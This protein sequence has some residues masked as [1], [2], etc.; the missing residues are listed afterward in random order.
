MEYIL[1]RVVMAK[2]PVFYVLT[3]FILLS[4]TLVAPSAH[5]A[6]SMGDCLDGNK[7]FHLKCSGTAGSSSRYCYLSQTETTN[8]EDGV[9]YA[10]WFNVWDV[11]ENSDNKSS[12]I[13]LEDDLDFGGYDDSKGACAVTFT[14]IGSG[15]S[16]DG[17]GK[18]IKGFCYSAANAGFFETLSGKEFKN[19]TFENPYVIGQYAGVVASTIQDASKVSHV[20]I[21]NASLFGVQLGGLAAVVKYVNNS[22]ENAINNV[23]IDGLSL[24][25]DRTYL[26]QAATFYMGSAV[27]YVNNAKVSV[28]NANVDNISV[29]FPGSATLYLGGFFGETYNSTVNVSNSIITSNAGLEPEG[30]GNLYVGGVVG[31]NYASHLTV[32]KFGFNGNLSGSYAGGILGYLKDFTSPAKNSII[33]NTYTVGEIK[34]TTSA[35]YI[36]GFLEAVSSLDQKDSLYHNFHFGTDAVSEGVG[37]YAG[38]G[39]WGYSWPQGTLG[40]EYVADQGNIFGNVRNASSGLTPNESFGFHFNVLHDTQN[41]VLKSYMDFFEGTYN[42]SSSAMWPMVRVANGIVKAADMESGLF[43][44]LM[45]YNLERMGQ[46]AIWIS[47]GGLPTFAN[48]TDKPNHLVILETSNLYLNQTQEN[49]LTIKNQ[50]I[51]DSSVSNNSGMNPPDRPESVK[52]GIVSYTDAS[53][54]LNS[55]FLGNVTKLIDDGK[56]NLGVNV[57]LEDGS[58]NSVSLT[59]T[60]DTYQMLRFSIPNMFFCFKENGTELVFHQVASTTPD[61]ETCFDTWYHDD[62]SGNDAYSY[63]QAWLD[64]TDNG[65]VVLTS[66]VVFAGS[67]NTV[68]ADGPNAFKGKYLE[69]GSGDSFKS[70]DGNR[71]KIIGLCYVSSTARESVGFVKTNAATSRIENIAFSNIYFKLTGNN[72]NAGVALFNVSPSSIDGISVESSEFRADSVGAIAGVANE[73]ENISNITLSGVKLDGK[74]VGSVFGYVSASNNVSFSKI[75][76]EG[77]SDGFINSTNYAGGLVGRM[78]ALSPLTLSIKNTYTRGN[79]TCSNSTVGFLVS[80]L[81]NSGRFAFDI[82]NNYH[83]GTDDVSVSEG[84]HGIGWSSGFVRNFRNSISGTILYAEGDLEYAEKPIA[85]ATRG[86]GGAVHYYNGIISAAQMKSARFAAVLNIGGAANWTIDAGNSPKNDGLPFL[87]DDTDDTYKPIYAIGFDLAYFDEWADAKAKQNLEDALYYEEYQYESIDANGTQGIV[88]YTN[89]RRKLSTEDVNFVNSLLTDVATDSWEGSKVLSD[90]QTYTENMTYTYTSTRKVRYFCFREY[91]DNLFLSHYEYT[92]PPSSGTCYAYWYDEYADHSSDD[93]PDAYSFAQ[94]WLDER[95]NGGNIYIASDITFAGRSGDYCI[96]APNAFKGKYLTLDDGRG[97]YSQPSERHVIYT[98]SGLCYNSSSARNIGFVEIKHS[99]A[100]I[101]DIAFSDVFFKLTGST[102]NTSAGLVMLQAQLDLLSDIRVFRSVFQASYAGSILGTDNDMGVGRLENITVDSDTITSSNYAGAVAGIIHGVTAVKGVYASDCK[103]SILRSNGIVIT[104]G[105]FGGIAGY[106]ANTSVASLSVSNVSVN[107]VAMNAVNSSQ[108]GGVFGHLDAGAASSFQGITVSGDILGSLVGGLVGEIW[109]RTDVAVSIKKTRILAHLW[110]AYDSDTDVLGGLIGKFDTRVAS[111]VG[112]LNINHNFITGA[113][114]SQKSQS[115]GY[116]LGSTM[117]NVTYNVTDNYYY[118]NNNISPQVGIVGIADWNNPSLSSSIITRNFR[119]AVDGS[120]EKDGD[121]QYAT[122]PIKNGDGTFDNGVIPGE[123]MKSARFAAVLNTDEAIWTIDEGDS[124]FNDGLPYFSE[125]SYRPIYVVRFDLNNFNEL[126]ADESHRNILNE[127]ISHNYYSL[128]NVDGTHKG[129]MLFTSNSGKLNDNDYNFVNSLLD[130]EASWVGSPT[131]NSEY[132]TEYR[133]NTIYTYN[134]STLMNIVNHFC[135]ANDGNDGCDMNTD[136]DLSGT[137]GLEVEGYSIGYLLPPLKTYRLGQA[138]SLIPPLMVSDGNSVKSYLPASYMINSLSPRQYAKAG[139]LWGMVSDYSTLS[140]VIQS[141]DYSVYENTIHLYY[142]NGVGA[143]TNIKVA[144]DGTTDYVVNGLAFD[145]DGALNKQVY[146]KSIPAGSY[147]TLPVTPVIMLEKAPYGFNLDWSLEFSYKTATN[148]NLVDN[149]YLVENSNVFASKY[150]TDSWK[151]ENR[152]ENDKVHL[153][154]IYTGL[155]KAFALSQTNLSQADFMITITPTLTPSNYSVTFDWGDKFHKDTLLVFSDR[156]YSQWDDAKLENV[157]MLAG[158]KFSRVYIYTKENATFQSISWTHDNQSSGYSELSSALL[159]NATGGDVSITD[160]SLY[161][162]RGSSIAS[163]GLINVF[164]YDGDGNLLTSADDYHGNV[165]LSQKIG[166]VEFKQESHFESDVMFR[167]ENYKNSDGLNVPNSPKLFL[168]G[169]G[170]DTLTFDV[171]AKAD[172]GY[173]MNV[174]SFTHG[175][176]NAPANEGWGYDADTKKLKIHTEKMQGA[177]PP[178]VPAFDYPQFT[179]E[180]I[181]LHYYL[182]FTIPDDMRDGDVFVANRKVVNGTDETYEVD[183]FTT[184]DDVT[185][186]TVKVPPLYNAEGCRINWRPATGNGSQLAALPIEEELLYLTPSTSGNVVNNVLVPDIDN[187]VCVQ[188]QSQYNTIRVD[189]AATQG[190]LSVMQMLAIPTVTPGVFDSIKIEYKINSDANGKYFDVPQIFDEQSEPLGV[191]LKAVVVP[192]N[193]YIFNDIYYEMFP[194]GTVDGNLHNGDYVDARGYGEWDVRFIELKPVY[195]EYDLSVNSADLA[196]VNLPVEAAPTGVLE[197]NTYEDSVAFWKPF[198]TDDKCFMGWSDKA[199]ALFSAATDSLY[200]VLSAN[201]YH[202]FESNTDENSAKTLYAI[203]DD[204][205]SLPAPP[206]PTVA[207]TN[208]IEHATLALYQMFGNTKISHKVPS[209]ATVSLAGDAFD[210]YVDG[211]SS[212]ADAGYI[213]DNTLNKLAYTYVAGTETTSPVEVTK[214]ATSGAYRVSTLQ[215]VSE[216]VTYTFTNTALPNEYTF[217]YDKNTDKAVVY[218]ASA[219]ESE[220]YKLTDASEE[221]PLQ[222][223]DVMIRA[224]ACLAGWSLDADGSTPLEKFDFD[225]LSTLNARTNTGLPVDKLYAIWT[226]AGTAACS[227]KTFTV[228]SD[229]DAERGL[230]NVYQVITT[231]TGTDKVKF[232][233]DPTEGVKIPAVENMNL[234]VEFVPAP[235]YI[236]M[237]EI[238]GVNASD[239][240][241]VLFTLDHDGISPAVYGKTFT[242][243]MNQPD[244]LLKPD[245]SLDYL[246][247]TFNEN[248]PTATAKPFLGDSWGNVIASSWCRITEDNDG[249]W[250]VFDKYTVNRRDEE[251]PKL[252]NS[253]Y[254]FKGYTFAK[255]DNTAGVF[256]KFDNDFI[257]AHQNNGANDATQLYAYWEQCNTNDYTVELLDKDKGTYKF[258][259]FFRGQN[260]QGNNSPKEREYVIPAGEDLKLPSNADDISFREINFSVNADVDSI[261]ITGL[262]TDYVFELVSGG[263]DLKTSTSIWSGGYALTSDVKSV[264]V[265]LFKN[266]YEFAYSRNV[267]DTA[268]VFFGTPRKFSDTYKIDDATASVALPL[269]IMARTDACLTGWTLEKSGGTTL[270]AFNERTLRILADYVEDGKSVDSLYAVWA[271]AGTAGCDPK[272]F[273]VTT[274]VPAAKGIFEVYQ[275]VR[276]GPKDTLWYKVTPGAN[277]GVVIPT[278]EDMKL[279]VKFSGANGYTVGAEVSVDDGTTTTTI[280]N[281]KTF[282]VVDGQPDVSL[283]ITTTAVTYHFA[284]NEND[285][286]EAYFGDSWADI[287]KATTNSVSTDGENWIVKAS[288]SLGGETQFPTAL[289]RAD[290]CLYGYTFETGTTEYFT[291]LN[292][293]FLIEFNARQENPAAYTTLYALW[294]DCQTAVTGQTIKLANADKGTYTFSRKFAYGTAND[295]STDARTYATTSETFVIPSDNKDVSFTNV[296]FKVNDGESYIL[297]TQKKISV[298]AKGEDADWSE[299]TAGDL[300]T[301]KDN[302]VDS[303]K[304]PVLK[305]SYMF[306]YN[307]NFDDGKAVFYSP[308]MKASETYTIADVTQFKSLLP[309]TVMGRTNACMSGWTLDMNDPTAKIDVFDIVALRKIN[310]RKAAGKDVSKLYAIWDNAGVNGCSPKT[311]TVTTDVPTAQGSFQVYQYVEGIHTDTVKYDV[312]NGI[313]IPTVAGMNLGIKFTGASTYSFGTEITVKEDVSGNEKIVDNGSSIPVADD[314]KN[315]TLHMEGEPVKY[316]F[317]FNENAADFAIKPYFGDSWQDLIDASTFSEDLSNGNWSVKKDYTVVSPLDFPMDLYSNTL[318]LQ[319]YGFTENSYI[320]FT[321]LTDEVIAKYNEATPP[322]QY[323][324][325]NPMPLYAVW[326]ACTAVNSVTVNFADLDKGKYVFYRT[327]SKGNFTTPERI[328]EVTSAN[329]ANGYTIPSDNDDIS[330]TDW[331][332]VVDPTASF[333]VDTD[334]LFAYRKD[335]SS[336][337]NKIAKGSLFTITDDVKNVNAPLLTNTY[338]FAYSANADSVFFAPSAE[339]DEVTYSLADASD[340]ENL[341]KLDVMAR[342]NACLDGWSLDKAGT[343]KISSFNVTALRTLDSLVKEGAPVDTLYAVWNTGSGCTQNTFTVTTETPVSKGKFEVYYVAGSGPEDTLWYKVD[344]GNSGVEIPTIANMKLGVK[345]TGAV[346]YTFGSTVFADTGATAKINVD[347]GKTFEVK[348]GQKNIVLSVDADV[349]IYNL[350]F[351]ENDDGAAFFGDSWADLIKATTNSVTKDNNG[352]WIVKANYSL[353]SQNKNFPMALYREGM[354]LKGYTFETGSTEYYTELNDDFINAFNNLGKNPAE[355]IVLYAHWGTCATTVTGDTI[356]LVNGN[357]GTYRFSRKFDLGTVDKDSTFARIYES[358]SEKFVV[359]SDNKDISFTNVEF[360]VNDGFGLILD[361]EKPIA[362]RAAPDS[363]IWREFTGSELLT[364]NTRIDSVKAPL[365]KNSYTFVY[366]KNFGKDSAVFFSPNMKSSALYSIENVMQ[367]KNLQDFNVMART[368]A[369]V[370]GWSLTKNGNV[371]I[372]AFDAEALRK[373][374]SL[375]AEN[376]DVGTLYAVW[377][378]VETGVCEP[379]TF[380]VT[381]NVP[382]AQGSFKLYRLLG[383]DTTWYNMNANGRFEIPTLVNMPLGFKFT[384]VSTYEFSPNITISDADGDE[385]EVSNGDTIHIVT[386]QKNLTL[387]MN[388]KAV[389]YFFALNENADGKAFF[390]DSWQSYIT[391]TTFNKALDGNWI[392][393]TAYTV[394]SAEKDFPTA[395]YSDDQCLQGYTLAANSTAGGLFTNFND[396]LI[397]KYQA[398]GSDSTNPL[399]LYAYWG[400]CSA[401]QSTTVKLADTDKGNYEF[402]KTFALGDGTFAKRTYSAATAN[403]NVP[404]NNND[405]SFNGIKFIVKS[406]IDYILD[407]DAKL[408]VKGT[409]A[410]ANWTDYTDG[411]ELTVGASFGFVKAPL[412]KNSYTFAYDKNFAKDS[413]VF[414]SSDVTFN[415]TYTLADV[416]QSKDLQPTTVMGRAD[417]CLTGWA[418]NANGSNVID[419]FDA[420]ALRTIN[421]L[422]ANGKDVGTLYAVWTAKGTGC[423]P[424]TFKVTTPMP[425]EQGSFKLYRLL[426]DDTTWYNVGTNGIEIP[427]FAGTK[428]GVKFTAASPAYTFGSDVVGSDDAGNKLFSSKNGETFDVVDLQKNVALSVS[429]NAVEYTFAFNENAAGDAFFGNVWDDYIDGSSFSSDNKGNWIVTASYSVNSVNKSFPMAMYREGYCMTGYTFTATDN[430]VFTELD[431]DFIRKFAALGKTSP[432]TLYAHWDVCSEAGT[433]VKLAGTDK[434]KYT[435]TRTFDLGNV[436]APAKRTYEATNENFVI[437]S[438]NGDVSF[439]EVAFEVIASDVIL[440]TDAKFSVKGTA[441]TASWKDYTNGYT[442]TV[443]ADLGSVK[444]PLLKNTYT[445]TYDKNYAKDSAVFYSPDVKF[446]GTYT[447]ASVAESKLVQSTTVM[448]RADACLTGWALDKAGNTEIGQFDATALRTINALEVAGKNVDTLYAVWTAKGADCSP[449]TFKVASGMP[450]T[451]GGF[452]L[453]RVLGADTTWYDVGTN[454]IE[455]PTLTGMKLGVKFTAISPAYTFGNNVSVDVGGTTP[456]SF[457]NGKTFE[458]AASQKNAQ[459]SVTSNAVEYML[460]FNENDKGAAYFGNAWNSLI[461]STTLS[462]DANKNWVVKAGYSVDMNDANKKFPMAMYRDGYCLQGY[463]FAAND[464][465]NGIYTELDDTFIAK[466]SA[467]GK[468]SANTTLYAYWGECSAT[469]TTVK[470]ADTDKGTFKFTRSFAL[471]NGKFAERTYNAATANFVVPSK[472]NDVSFNAIAFEVNSTAGVILDTDAK[473]SVKGV[474]STA[475]W[476]DYTNGDTLT[477]GANFGSVK[478]PLLK[479]SYTFA[480]SKNY[481]VDSAVFYS[482]NMK[483]SGTYTIASV[484]ES[485]SLQALNVMGRSDAC[486]TGWALDKAGKTIIGTFDAEA[487][488]TLNATTAT[489]TLYAVW[490]KKGSADAA[491]TVCKP[492]TFTVTSG[493]PTVQGSFKVYRVLNADTTWYNVGTNGIEIP[494]LAGMKLGVK[495]TGFAAYTFGSNVLGSDASGTELFSTKNGNMFTVATAQ[496]NV[497]LS[498]TSKEVTYNFAFN[499]NAGNTSVFNGTGLT[500][501]VVKSFTYGDTLPLNLYRTE[502][503]LVGWS[504]KPLANANVG[505]VFTKVDSAFVNAYGSM[506]NADT[507]YAVWTVNSTRKTYTIAITNLVEEGLFELKNASSVYTVKTGEMLKIPAESDLL[508]TVSFK[509]NTY[510]WNEY[511]SIEVLDAKSGKRLATVKAGDSYLFTTNVSLRAVGKFSPVQFAL[512]ANAGTNKVFFGDSFNEFAWTAKSF[513]DVLP[514]EIYRTD[515]VLAGWSLD[516]NATKG[517][518]TFDEKLAESY[519]TFRSNKSNVNKIPVLYAVWQKKAVQTITVKADSVAKGTLTLK[520][521]VGDS[522]FAHAVSDK[523]MKV[524]F[525]DNGLIFQAHFDVNDSW[526]MNAKKPLVWTTAKAKDSTA[527][528]AFKV[529]NTDVTVKVLAVFKEFHFVFDVSGDSLFYGDDWK[530]SG[531]FASTD[532]KNETSFPTMVYN[533]DS[534]VAGWSVKIGTNSYTNL[535]DTMISDLYA[536]YPN[537]NSSM[538][539]KLYAQWTSN[540]EDCAGNITRIEV[541]QQH[542][543]VHLIENMAKSKLVH[544]FNKYGSML[545]PAEIESDNW[546]VRTNP[547]SSFVLD[548][549]VVMRN[550]KKEEVLHEGDHLPTNMENVVLKAFFGKANKTPIEI[551]D[552][553]FAQSGNAVRVGFKMSE[554]EVTRGVAARVRI[555]DEKG[556]VVVDSLLSDSIASAFADEVI[557]RVHKPGAYKML[558]S[559]S[560]GKETAKYDELFTVSSQ[561]TSFAA[562][563]WH[564]ISLA[565]VDTAAINWNGYTHLYWWDDSY[566]GQYWQYKTFNRGDEV[567]GIRGVWYSSQDGT[568]LVIRTDIEDAGEDIVWEL[569]SIG[570][571]WNL[572]ANPHGWRM[573]LYSLNPPARKKIDEMAEVS[574]WRYN[575]EANDYEEVDMIEPYEAVWAKVSKKIQWNVSAKPIFTISSA[576][577]TSKNVLSKRTLA[578]ASTKDRWTLQAMLE[579]NNGNRDSWNILGVSNN[580][581]VAEEPPTSLGDHV[582]L[583]IVEGKHGLAKSIKDADAEMEWTIALSA[584]S[585]RVG[586]LS[587][588]GIKDINAFGYHVYVTVDG[589]TTEMKEG[590]PLQVSLS[591]KP[592]NATVRVERGTI[593][594]AQKSGLKGLRSAKLGNQLHVSF[595][596]PDELVDESTRVELLTAKGGVVATASARSVFGTNKVMMDLPK[597]GV[598]ILRVRVGSAH[599][600]RQILVK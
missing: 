558:L 291:E 306:Y 411:D 29:V 437:P 544:K 308:A 54:S 392:V 221:L 157:D 186:A 566:C 120:L 27:G 200:K 550:G 146:G 164:A 462:T 555:T 238:T 249:N 436:L 370:V 52:K 205:S 47:D 232:E 234:E 507:L 592:K 71:H 562:N 178:K 400:A 199:A 353:E 424:K 331:E 474:A 572:V 563:R 7:Y 543:D 598:Y 156:A 484:A 22:N 502:A 334:S 112:K 253:G 57:V 354:C 347:N 528:D 352:N 396:N 70:E 399:M 184:Q 408:S 362:L 65:S 335:P 256:T 397:A 220:T 324:S 453:Y 277:G 588:A 204:C 315:L 488:R 545:L 394:E 340:S 418:L 504:L 468:N 241:E 311:F 454:G 595:E 366:D 599:L 260:F 41:N 155:L 317:A 557:M 82:I 403:F 452:K 114:E 194:V 357:K 517:S 458:V 305:N 8:P 242:V 196:S 229:V 490:T 11:L 483:N 313:E 318:C 505:E 443:G 209:G 492:T 526:S 569:D 18:T 577:D 551:V 487:L 127:A 92:A 99:N 264:R 252:Y 406:D 37:N 470:L 40:S 381:S 332:F 541:D 434:G 281:G 212:V 280:A 591:S 266:K 427:T 272:T 76:V 81:E 182:E 250:K 301:V 333:I 442:L 44:A 446:S 115:N 208:G 493:M 289:Y 248:P 522:S 25:Q 415:G 219:K 169:L 133:A 73:V 128:E 455:I 374:D 5:A 469:G 72:T 265:P 485:K 582:N 416:L 320:A 201:N 274:G 393:T 514:T 118:R 567:I 380:S 105:I 131:W 302:K 425:A 509:P 589:T 580:P 326:G 510:N 439:D 158:E 222:T 530:K 207:L 15:H 486:L 34:G 359:P 267:A 336:A 341:K 348:N 508:F 13:I 537:I 66:N 356:K 97:L 295:D 10:C 533:T 430:D 423:T 170:Y 197:I 80:D 344:P 235:G 287:I 110:T 421:A 224:D 349:V 369:C 358:T 165:V 429:S 136:N 203:W 451:Q 177:S 102:Y 153:D 422:E 174:L 32:N 202:V 279:G 450:E 540:V 55:D 401:A 58:G 546:T 263:T 548:S 414:Y 463:T 98:I 438:S 2:N 535:Q 36:I 31:E 536:V 171:S 30:T 521:F 322:N 587:F 141:L 556:T 185:A 173:S 179:V 282:D 75:A 476:T 225:A 269:D 386:G 89:S 491:G 387:N 465:T 262:L 520:Q 189:I 440:D 163:P 516:K 328:Y 246:S 94:K 134:A 319:G 180:F 251:F 316:Y 135:T 410:T 473:L 258:V 338:K 519:N 578:K 23:T 162:V 538:N 307:R 404:S 43:A 296:E 323:S 123:Q 275:V 268:K 206:T 59:E 143:S 74:F 402:T 247:V 285:V 524:P 126:T 286:G 223:L 364:V 549:L 124:P 337:W 21:K 447:L 444:A 312:G 188:G 172:P 26:S 501:T 464:K 417:A 445:F 53:G 600:T 321:K 181:P 218:A 482:P 210:F 506:V 579:D 62:G 420:T 63:A 86:R 382:A 38:T 597:N 576:A 477:V 61:D 498:V 193:G 481:A 511:T 160:L 167:G 527:N 91:T 292:D 574:F 365:L 398:A 19:V 103:L 142:V 461:S 390:G 144:N 132:K 489:D 113:L 149:S 50:S 138:N 17:R 46:N 309:T 435:F 288:Y 240:S 166:N 261:V 388:A 495:F 346:G 116:L 300:L 513:E 565:P 367:F 529:V 150:T 108:M 407:T 283:D 368:D 227:P 448:G 88:L 531:D 586:N 339:M 568:P 77:S 383:T 24:V 345:F 67:T 532:D 243:A 151:I 433:T 68:C 467:L 45:N 395:L 198:R 64:N 375:T 376:Q 236:T 310:E 176:D 85:V 154:S 28:S 111:A 554:F 14:P 4:A 6:L 472:N 503:T 228:T 547:D 106:V 191:K 431:D 90:A 87:V 561:M 276:N 499:A 147:V 297:D 187:P 239:A 456:I 159:E 119:N 343:V 298:K 104:G 525:V 148:T 571:G 245:V 273:K 518:V 584:T 190:D 583:S 231:A 553:N 419:E 350:A 409:A 183:W 459:L 284:F 78:N 192:K 361:T 278:I 1:K 441:S 51:R 330:F 93:P 475:S 389:K 449:T 460:A 480:Y 378:S 101:G 125:S 214:D 100:G 497:K 255:D 244:V 107:N 559:F 145:A 129:I 9:D 79:I 534:C 140:S 494:T 175:W 391:S 512:N 39:N 95:Q 542:G 363:A 327:F 496:K 294:G 270:D 16:F 69:L 570:S 213:L 271:D 60:F 351:H 161:P 217:I 405:I 304:A 20:I 230:F 560:D 293:A 83:Y 373:L 290:K 564:M 581:F 314:Q 342:A 552:K 573:D 379:K 371:K 33:K 226:A 478:A 12:Q 84:I 500:T 466:F 426:G 49:D 117:D 360:T 329:A 585:N 575:A 259:Q 233:V 215:N 515:A 35:G 96:D 121:L 139:N 384:G 594:V 355:T 109:Y 412:L 130:K 56:D 299:Y 3:A 237:R 385:K 377:N 413:A 471:G 257:I 325:T 432:T 42:P 254:C 372:G 428:L 48:G 596:V 168:P 195:V 590:T 211:N 523:G 152:T 137:S 479:N 216:L 539:V 457:A 122:K 303:V 593:A